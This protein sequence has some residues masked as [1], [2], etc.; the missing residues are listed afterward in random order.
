MTAAIPSR[1]PA[2]RAYAWR[3]FIAFE[4]TN[5]VGNVYFARFVSWQGRCREAFLA[6]HAAEVV[7]RLA[8]DLRLVTLSVSCE[9]YEELRVFDAVTIEM[10]LAEKNAHRIALSFDYQLDRAGM[11]RLA[12]SGAQEVACMSL[13]GGRLAPTE[14]PPSLAAALDAYAAEG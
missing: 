9:F 12:A 4:D 13:V 2:G 1:T 11:T 7:E 14:I 3:P 10:R 6:E 5:L 8:R